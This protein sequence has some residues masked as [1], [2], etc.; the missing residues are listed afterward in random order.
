MDL[1][2]IAREL[3]DHLKANRREAM[4]DSNALDIQALCVA[5][6][7]GELVGAYRRW[8]GKARRTGTLAEVEAELADVLI[9]TAIFAEVIGIDIDKAVSAKLE[10]IYS[11]GWKESK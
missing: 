1:Q 5:E 10:K 8:A 9:V 3:Q 7:A 6:E 2:Q 11:R 4:N